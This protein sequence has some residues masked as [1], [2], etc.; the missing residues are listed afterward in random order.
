MED[1]GLTWRC[2]SGGRRPSIWRARRAASRLCCRNWA[3]PCAAM[4]RRCLRRPG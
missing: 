4:V 1:A 2:W 3:L